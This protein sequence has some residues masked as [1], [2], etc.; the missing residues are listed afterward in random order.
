MSFKGL[1]AILNETERRQSANTVPWLKVEDG[2][3]V[4]IRFINELDADSPGYDP[5]RG[6]AIAVDEHVDPTNFRRKLACTKEE[7]GRCWACEQAQR[8]PK[9]RWYAKMRFYINVLV[10][11][12]KSQPR[13]CV[14]SM[15]T[16]RS[17]TFDTIKEYY[18]ESGQISQTAWRLKKSGTGTDTVYSLLPLAQDATPFDWTGI[19][20]FELADVVQ[21]L[22][23]EEQQAFFM[24][25]QEDESANIW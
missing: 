16:R 13:V 7:L 18:F 8:D 15:A 17:A 3:V 10:D 21:T 23:Y 12:G 2:Q 5:A 11:D 24:P 4:K 19:E 1:K 20:P 6:L 14:W 9:G 22:P 25:V